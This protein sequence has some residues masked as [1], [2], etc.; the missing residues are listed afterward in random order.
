M[1]L[2]A[3]RTPVGNGRFT[4]RVFADDERAVWISSEQVAALVLPD[5][6]ESAQEFTDEDGRTWGVV[7]SLDGPLALWMDEADDLWS[8][9]GDV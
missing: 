3:H 7:N 8:T 1:E 5:G 6:V 4:N 9:L 2:D